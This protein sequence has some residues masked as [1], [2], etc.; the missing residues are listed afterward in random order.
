MHRAAAGAAWPGYSS[1]MDSS[2]YPA[3]RARLAAALRAAGGGVAVIPTAPERNRNSDND[4]PYRHDSSFHHLTGF[5]EPGAWLVLNASGAC[6]IGCR[7]KNPEME[8]W[9]GV[10]LGVDAAPAALGVDSA[11]DIET[12][13]AFMLEWLAGAPAVWFPFEPGAGVAPRIDGWL[14]TLRSRARSGV[15]APTAVRDLAPLL[16]AMRV[17]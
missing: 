3:R 14:A 2:V 11:F 8:I 9:E 1:G 12:L 10:R 15:E 13:D 6:A 16:A 17:R 7:A 4:H 5:D